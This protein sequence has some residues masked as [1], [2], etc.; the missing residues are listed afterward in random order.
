[1]RADMELC[2]ILR[3]VADDRRVVEV[4]GNTV[5]ECL[6]DASGQFPRLKEWISSASG[7]SLVVVRVNGEVVRRQ[8]FSRR[9]ADGDE[10]KLNALPGNG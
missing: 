3:Q 6:N 1:M 2:P 4:K 5:A 8:D 10:L 9:V 7:I